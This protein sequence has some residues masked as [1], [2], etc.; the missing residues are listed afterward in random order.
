MK[1]RDFADARTL[2]RLLAQSVPGVGG[3]LSDL[4]VMRT[5]R[6]RYLRLRSEAIRA[7]LD[8]D[9]SQFAEL[10]STLDR[11]YGKPVDEGDIAQ[12]ALRRQRTRQ[13]LPARRALPGQ[14]GYVPGQ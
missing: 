14:P 5:G 8:H 7:A 10:N 11:E 13:G 1:T 2:L 6:A 4:P 3:R 9:E 12:E